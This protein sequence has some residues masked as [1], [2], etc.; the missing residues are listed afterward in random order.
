MLFSHDNNDVTLMS[1]YFPLYPH[2]SYHVPIFPLVSPHTPRVPIFSIVSPCSP[3]A[4]IFPLMFPSFPLML[5]SMI[6]SWP[7]GDTSSIG[8]NAKRQ[9]GSQRSLN[10]MVVTISNSHG[11]T[12]C[13]KSNTTENY[14]KPKHVS[15]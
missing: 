9:R 6:C 1:P 2:I 10:K 5:L 7:F 3:Y 13:L 8:A 4:P 12:S 15:C 14:Y 11:P